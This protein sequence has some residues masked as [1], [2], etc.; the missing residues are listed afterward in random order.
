MNSSGGAYP[1]EGWQAAY[2]AVDQR[3]SLAEQRVAVR[4]PA[5]LAAV[6]PPVAIGT[7]GCIYGVRRWGFMLRPSA[8]EAAGFEPIMLP[9]E[10]DDVSIMGAMLR[11]AAYELPGEY[12]IA[13]P[14]H[15][16]RLVAHDGIMRGSSIRWRTYLGALAFFA[17][18]GEIDAPFIRFWAEAEDSYRVAVD[19]CLM[20]LKAIPCP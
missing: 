10:S 4:V 15:P 17:S 12:I 19:H 16:F 18:C 5:G 3:G 2:F 8:L 11:A 6:C 14:E 7:P 13:S 20:T 9:A 1:T